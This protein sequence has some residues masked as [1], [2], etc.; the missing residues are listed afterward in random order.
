MTCIRALLIVGALLAPGT[1]Y[2][3]SP[4]VIQGA[5]VIDG[6][7]RVPLG[8]ATI[9][10]SGGGRIAS[11]GAEDAILAATRNIARAYRKDGELGTIEPGKRADLV[12]LD[13]DPLRDIGNVEKIA[14]VIKDGAVVDRAALPVK[15]ILTSAGQPKP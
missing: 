3:P 8:N 1:G 10:M 13:A 12:L 14:A 7:G 5:T 4:L 15:R 9:V 11:V 6:T 2:G